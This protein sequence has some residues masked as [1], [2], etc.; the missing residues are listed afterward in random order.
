[1]FSRPAL[2][3]LLQGP[4]SAVTTRSALDHIGADLR[5]RL[6]EGHRRVAADLEAGSA[7]RAVDLQGHRRLR[8]A[9]HPS[10]QRA[11]QVHTGASA[12]WLPKG[13]DLLLREAVEAISAPVAARLGL[14]D[15]DPGHPHVGELLLQPAPTTVTFHVIIPP[16]PQTP[17][18]AL[19]CG[20]RTPRR[21]KGR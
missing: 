18:A 21:R 8:V 10:L 7:P 11:H 19:S 15:I 2:E 20:I 17:R 6:S 16:S 5:G 13:A 4:R 9:H 12:P 3:G 1:R 14:V